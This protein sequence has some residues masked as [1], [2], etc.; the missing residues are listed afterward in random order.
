MQIP[1]YTLEL[2]QA[3]H[4]LAVILL[5]RP[6]CFLLC[7]P[8]TDWR[9]PHRG[10]H[11]SCAPAQTRLVMRLALHSSWQATARPGM[12]RYALPAICLLLV[13]SVY[14]YLKLLIVW[15]ARSCSICWLVT[16]AV[17]NSP[18]TLLKLVNIWI[19]ATGWQMSGCHFRQGRGV[20]FIS[21]I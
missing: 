1:P 17:Q 10:G 7:R 8:L 4:F 2:Q 15:P 6:F 16:C 21:D 12:L 20:P 14:V 13:A 3:D 11:G 19:P 9:W 18:K 5:L